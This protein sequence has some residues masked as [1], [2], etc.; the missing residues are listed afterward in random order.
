MRNYPIF[1]Y[2]IPIMYVQ[3]IVMLRGPKDRLEASTIVEE[4]VDPSRR[5]CFA[6]SL[7]VTHY[8]LCKINHKDT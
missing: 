6:K 1:L 3:T 2:V 5:F 8:L 7:R 4:C